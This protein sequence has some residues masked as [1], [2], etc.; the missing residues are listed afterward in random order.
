MMNDGDARNA[1]RIACATCAGA[2]AGVRLLSRMKLVTSVVVSGRRKALRPNVWTVVVRQ[3]AVFV[4]GS[5]LMN[6]ALLV[7]F[8]MTWAA[9]AWPDIAP[10]QA[11]RLAT[12]SPTSPSPIPGFGRLDGVISFALPPAVQ[13]SID[14]VPHGAAATAQ[15]RRR[16]PYRWV[17]RAHF[18]TW[19]LQRPAILGRRVDQRR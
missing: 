16:P 9:V 15:D 7:V 5:Q 3:V 1:A 11:A 2:P 4:V 12:S 17:R 14:K 13:R 6:L 10:V 18:F 8:P 19:W